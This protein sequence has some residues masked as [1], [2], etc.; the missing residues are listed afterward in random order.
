MGELGVN[1]WGSH[2]EYQV[3]MGYSLNATPRYGIVQNITCHCTFR[4]QAA[5]FMTSKFN[6]TH[7][8]ITQIPLQGFKA[9]IF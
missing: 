7:C 6:A 4:I 1:I 3:T 9:T 5:I 2:I 8:Y